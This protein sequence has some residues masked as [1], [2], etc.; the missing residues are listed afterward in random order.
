LRVLDLNHPD[1][2]E[3]TLVHHGARLAHHRI[4]A[5]V[6]GQCKQAAAA[7]HGL[8]QRMGIGQRGGHGLVANHVNADFQKR[9][10]YRRVQVVGRDD[11]H[12]V[13]AILARTLSLGHC[14]KVGIAAL[15][16]NVQ[17]GRAGRAARR[18]GR[19]RARHQGVSII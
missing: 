6:V 11:C 2:T 4:A 3:L 12:H 7:A 15:G 16:C 1:L 17:P 9:L 10:G 19:E 18:V 14:G 8:D 5:V 13:N